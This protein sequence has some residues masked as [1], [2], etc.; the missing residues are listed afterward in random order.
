MVSPL[1][2]TVCDNIFN[3]QIKKK[4]RE[5]KKLYVPYLCT[6][7]FGKLYVLFKEFDFESVWDREYL[8]PRSSPGR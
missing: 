6:I 1:Y 8:K 4:E 2:I 5:K 7:G 3:T